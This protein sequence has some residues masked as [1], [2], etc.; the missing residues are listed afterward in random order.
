[1]LPSEVGHVAKGMLS[2]TLDR[3]HISCETGELSPAITQWAAS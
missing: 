1:M 3:H 2:R